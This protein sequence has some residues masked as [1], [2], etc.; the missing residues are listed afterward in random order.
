MK[1]Q[2]VLIVKDEEDCLER[3]LNSVKGLPIL[4]I[5]SACYGDIIK[6]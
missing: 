5:R 1:L 3:C 4:I 6:M 2:V